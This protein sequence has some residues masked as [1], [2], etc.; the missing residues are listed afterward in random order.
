[1]ETNKLY[2][3]TGNEY[4]AMSDPSSIENF[5]FQHITEPGV[6]VLTSERILDEG[7][8]GVQNPVMRNHVGCVAGHEQALEARV[9]GKEPFRH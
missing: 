6:Q 3:V 7:D 5:H 2:P 1:M 8:A 4:S 9:K